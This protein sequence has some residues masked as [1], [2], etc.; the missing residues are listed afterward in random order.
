MIETRGL[1]SAFHP[2]PSALRHGCMD[3]QVERGSQPQAGIA[4]SARH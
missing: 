4:L 1:P 3:A 2:S